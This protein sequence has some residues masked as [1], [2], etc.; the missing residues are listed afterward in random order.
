MLG[1]TVRYCTRTRR[2]R[3]EKPVLRARLFLRS[4][5][6]RDELPVP[7]V[8]EFFVS[9]LAAQAGVRADPEF[10]IFE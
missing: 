1:G 10:L 5:S 8:V 7:N 6:H 9:F 3:R 4:F 2:F